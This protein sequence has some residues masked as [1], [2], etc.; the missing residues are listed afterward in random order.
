MKALLKMSIVAL[1]S[2]VALIFF[3]STAFGKTGNDDINVVKSKYKNLFVFRTEKKLAGATVEVLS[4]NGVV[5]TSQVLEKRK[6]IIDFCDVRFG[7]YTIRVTKGNN[8]KE[9]HYIKKK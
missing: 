2:I 4:E 6:M 5:V 9:Y 8:V 1:V 3:S 7:T